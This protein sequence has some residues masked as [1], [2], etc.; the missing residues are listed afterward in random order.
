MPNTERAQKGQVRRLLGRFW[1]AANLLSLSRLVLV[2]PITYL[3][4]TDGSMALLFGLIALAVLT[5]WFD[6]RLARW[7]KT[8]SEWG[9]VLDPLADKVAAAMITLALVVRGSLPL[10]L[11]VLIVLRDVFIVLGGMILAQRTA[12]VVMSI[13]MGK[14][15]VTALSITVLAA[16][17]QADE[18]VLTFCVWATAGLLV[19]SFLLY[20]LRF[21]RLLRRG[22]PLPAEGAG[23]TSGGPY[24]QT[25]DPGLADA[26]L[27]NEEVTG[28]GSRSEQ[29]VGAADHPSPDD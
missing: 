20:V 18:P 25:L 10:W 11:L 26:G 3:I 16:L 9:K 17:L 15:A 1:T 28:S 8:V 23:V 27:L 29:R 13:W 14:V 22:R 12:R 19:Y 4:L 5:D 6:G 7:S 2:V 24:T 21:I